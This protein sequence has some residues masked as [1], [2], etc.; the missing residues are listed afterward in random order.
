MFEKEKAIPII[1]TP[2]FISLVLILCIIFSTPQSSHSKS[3]E[4]YRKDIELKGIS[5]SRE[6]F[7]NELIAGNIDIVKKFIKAGIDVNSKN[8]DG[9]SAL[10]IALA[11]PSVPI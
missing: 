2:L 6:S 8:K 10:M 7:L 4:G 5:Y 11:K 9:E 3:R 1:K